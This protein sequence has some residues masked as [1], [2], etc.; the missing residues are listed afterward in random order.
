VT[1]VVTYDGGIDAYLVLSQG[2]SLADAE[3]AMS[4]QL[5]AYKRPRHV[6]VL[7]ELP[8]TATGKI[9]RDKAVLRAAAAAEPAVRP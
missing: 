5:A 2:S 3:I 9:V 1:A 8:R 4:D 6:Y 7:P